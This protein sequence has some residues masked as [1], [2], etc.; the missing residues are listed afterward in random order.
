MLFLF[1]VKPPPFGLAGTGGTGGA[2]V[3]FPTNELPFEDS[4][5]WVDGGV[6]SA[7]AEFKV[8][9]DFWDGTLSLLESLDDSEVRKLALD[10]RRRSLRKAMMLAISACLGKAP[11]LDQKHRETDAGIRSG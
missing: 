9:E 6:D 7:Y 1:D 3:A 4:A 5:G 8:D 10:R 2:A 11:C